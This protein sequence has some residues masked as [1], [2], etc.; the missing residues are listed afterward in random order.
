MLSNLNFVENKTIR[1]SSNLIKEP[2]ARQTFFLTET[3]KPKY[4]FFFIT[5][6]LYLL[7]I[8]TEIIEFKLAYLHLADLKFTHLTR[9]AP[10]LSD[11]FI[12]VSISLRSGFKT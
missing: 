5:A 3:T 4:R 11:V 7:R 8:T 12:L 1:F 9:T 6:G 10:E 2:S